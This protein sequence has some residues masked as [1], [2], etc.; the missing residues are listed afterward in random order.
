MGRHALRRG[1]LTAAVSALAVAVATGVTLSGGGEAAQAAVTPTAGTTE[2]VLDDPRTETPR[3][4][5]L[6]AAGTTGFLHRQSGVAGLLWT[7]YADGDTTPVDGPP[8]GTGYQP[9][10]PA[11]A[12]CGD[13]AVSCPSGTFGQGADTVALPHRTYTEPVSLWTPGGGTPRTLDM[14][15]SEYVGTYGSTVVAAHWDT[16]VDAE[17]RA[18]LELLDLTDG[19][20]RDRTVTGWPTGQEWGAGTSRRTGDAKGALISHPTPATPPAAPPPT[21]SAI[22]T[23]PPPSS[24][25]SSTV[26]T[27]ASRWCSPATG[28]AGTAR[29]AACI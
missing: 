21:T 3:V 4:E 28:S 7:S 17:P 22:S 10:Q 26:P 1:G 23:S 9:Y 5:R 19:G 20:Q 15:R 12:N 8:N 25:R 14:P 11:T 13:I 6:L 18:W 2:I 27:P 24:P 29:A 16:P